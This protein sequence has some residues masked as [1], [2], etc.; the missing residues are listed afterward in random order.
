VPGALGPM[1]AA[2]VRIFVVTGG[3]WNADGPALRQE[4]G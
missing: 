3:P 4:A 1:I 2:L